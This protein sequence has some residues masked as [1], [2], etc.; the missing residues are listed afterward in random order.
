ML[1]EFYA[2]LLTSHGLSQGL[3]LGNA[4]HA[5]NHHSGGQQQ[6]AG[7]RGISPAGEEFRS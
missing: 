5:V 4:Q 7:I 2:H 1:F 3:L 6:V